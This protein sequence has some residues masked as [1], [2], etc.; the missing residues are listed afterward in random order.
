M[1]N[2]GGKTHSIEPARGAGCSLC[3]HGGSLDFDFS[4][5]FQPIIDVRKARVF[6]HEA[7]IRGLGGEPAQTV[8]ERVN[9][10]NRYQFDQACRVR[11]IET[12]ARLGLSGKLSINFLPNAIYRPEVC[13]S[14]TL[15]AAETCGFPIDRIIFETVEGERIED[16]KWLAEVFREYQRIGFLTAIDDFGAGYAGLNLL[17]DFQ[18]DIIKLDM[19]LVRSIDKRKTS[20]AIVRAVAGICHELDIQLIAEGVET[21]DELFCLQ[22]AGVELIQGYLLSMPLFESC[23]HDADLTLPV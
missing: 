21:R 15:R 10:A 9:P 2:S 19:S 11:A 13:I 7:L 16:G 22:D 17:A 20:H 6:A 18:P 12:A 1:N 4:Y 8:L 3:R 5:A 14:T 23:L